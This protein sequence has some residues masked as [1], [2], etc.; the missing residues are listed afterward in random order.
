MINILPFHP[1]P[2]TVNRQMDKESDP[3]F[4]VCGHRM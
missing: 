2:S 4:N 1:D 3:N